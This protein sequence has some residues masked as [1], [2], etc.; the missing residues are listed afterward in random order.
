VL[1]HKQLAHFFFGDPVDWLTNGDVN[2]PATFADMADG[3]IDRGEKTASFNFEIWFCDLADVSANAQE[4]EIEVMSDLTSIAMDFKAMLSSTDYQDDWKI[5]D[6]APLTFY[7]EKFEDIVIAC[8]MSLTI[9]V[10]FDTNRCNVPADVV[11]FETNNS[12][13]II[14]NYVYTGSGAEGNAVTISSLIGKTILMLFK[15]DKLLTAGTL[16]LSEN[17]YLVNP[18]TGAFTFGT[19][20]EPT[21]VIQILNR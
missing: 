15:G 21:Q 5:E 17:Q 4:N 14:Q 3:V 2:Y 18:A 16:P 1:G 11:T 19:D 7:K 8:K 12:E 13:M 9:S 6:R 20:I 10:M